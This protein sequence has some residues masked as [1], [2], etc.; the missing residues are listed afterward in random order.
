M[1]AVISFL[2]TLAL[3]VTLAA[4]FVVVFLAVLKILK[5]VSLFSGHTAVIMAS[6]VA[7]LCIVGL[8]QLLVAPHVQYHK[9]EGGQK[10]ES[11]GGYELLPYVALSVAAAVILSQLLLI[12]GNV[13]PEE[14]RQELLTERQRHAETP[15]ATRKSR[16]RE[17]TDATRRSRRK[18]KTVK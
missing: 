4:I 14:A 16:T 10:V 9:L 8:A 18:I 13:S 17:K 11:S 12:G 2:P 5:N 7:V 15:R 1:N 3:L 6:C